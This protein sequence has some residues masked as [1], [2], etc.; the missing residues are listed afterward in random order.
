M[1]KVNQSVT[2]TISLVK[3]VTV[4]F[5]IIYRLIDKYC[6][7][8]E[9]MWFASCWDEQSVDFIDQFDP[10]CYKIASACLTDKELLNAC[11]KSCIPI[12]ISTGMST[13]KEIIEA[14]E[15]LKDS[16]KVLFHCNSSYPAK[17]NELNLAYVTILKLSYPKLKIGYSGHEEGISACVVAKVMGAEVFERHITLSRSN[18]G[19]DQAASL[20]FDQ[21]YRLV[22]DLNKVNIWIGLPI[23]KVYDSEKSIRKKLRE[24]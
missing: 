5:L 12:Y 24:V 10:P 18:W 15:I 9:I 13:E 19:T 6:K 21:L 3:I 17:D 1:W 23:K 2:K 8:K 16:L 7:E 20:V 11:K 14:V 22:R 4:L